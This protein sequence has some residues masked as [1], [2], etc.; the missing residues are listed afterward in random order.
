MYSYSV[1]KC[2]VIPL[3]DCVVTYKHLFNDKSRLRNQLTISPRTLLAIL[4]QIGS[5][6]DEVLKKKLL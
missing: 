6:L 5:D 2:F 1:T 4:T 3:R